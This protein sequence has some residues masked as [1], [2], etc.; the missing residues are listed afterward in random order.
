MSGL[1][2]PADLALP[3]TLCAVQDSATAISDLLG[4]VLLDDPLTWSLSGGVFATVYRAEN[5]ANLPVNQRLSVLATRLGIVAR[6]FHAVA[7]GNALL[8]GVL[9]AAPGDIDLDV[10]ATVTAAAERCGY[11]IVSV[12]PPATS[13]S[14]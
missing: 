9:G 4:G 13:G 14:R 3:L 6:A 7:R 5:R 2:V 11:R 8:L 1:L 12:I 10:P